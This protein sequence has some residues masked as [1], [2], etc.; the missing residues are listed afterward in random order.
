[1]QAIN[2]FY[3]QS[4][5]DLLVPGNSSQTNETQADHIYV[6]SDKK[7]VKIK[8]P[9]IL[10]IESIKD[11]VKI[12]CQ[13]RTVIAKMLISEMESMSSVGVTD[14][15]ILFSDIWPALAALFISH[16]YSSLQNFIGLRE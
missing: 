13:G 2:K 4:N 15:L 6:R 11:Y 9:E 5:S 7:N 8:F 3:E 10:Y 1:M 14:V 16:G 12:V